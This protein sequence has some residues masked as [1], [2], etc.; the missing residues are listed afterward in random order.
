MLI[1]YKT[2]GIQPHFFMDKI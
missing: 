1:S 2:L